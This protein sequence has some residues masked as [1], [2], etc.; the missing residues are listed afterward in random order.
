MEH[1]SASDQ[2]SFGFRNIRIGNAA[3]DRAGRGTFLV[4]EKS[5]AFS[6]FAGKD[7]INVFSQWRTSFAV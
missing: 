2:H 5:Y 3:V 6:A 7:V 1:A 4:I